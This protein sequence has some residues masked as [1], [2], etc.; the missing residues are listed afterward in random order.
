M[1]KIA[2]GQMDIRL[3][4]VSVN[5]AH[6]RAWV[7]EAAQRGAQLIVFPE[8]WATGYDLDHWQTHAAPLGAGLFAEIGALARAHRIA[9]AGSL[10]EA[11][12]GRAYNTLTLYDADGQLAAVYRKIHLFRLMEE[13]QWLAPGEEPVLAD[14]AWGRAGLAICYDLRFPELFRRYAL[15]GAR[16]LAL[17]AEWPARRRAHWQTLLR[18]RAI[19]NQSF[20]IA[21]NRVGASKGEVFGGGSAI[22][23]PWGETLIEGDDQPALLY[24]ELDLALVDDVRK[25]LPVW[26]DRRPELY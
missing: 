9:I 13:D 19:E 25:R 6:A 21:C 7:A 11:R 16:L 24:A 10:L 12:A 23:D 15:G 8:L 1:Y 18:A 26:A 2:L 14:G 22:I 17:P 3:G 4:D 5:L 20:V